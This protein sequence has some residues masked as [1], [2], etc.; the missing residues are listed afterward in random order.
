MTL[1]WRLYVAA[2]SVAAMLALGMAPPANAAEKEPVIRFVYKNPTGWWPDKVAQEVQEAAKKLGVDYQIIGPQ[3]ADV[4]KQVDMIEGFVSDKVDVLIVSSLGP[5][6][7][8]AV[9]DA[10]RDGIKVVM[11]DSDCPKSHRLAFFGANDTSLGADAGALY[12]EATKGK[13][14]Q[15]ILVVTG[16]P[17]AENLMQREQGFKDKLK[18]L[19]VDVQYLPTIPC[20]EDTQ[21]AVDAIESALRGDPTI[22]GVYVTAFW[23]FEA[24]AK[25]FPLMTKGVKDGKLTVVNVDGLPGA[26]KM[27]E[28]G[29]IYGSVAQNLGQFAV[30]PLN[31]AYQVGIKGIKYPSTCTL[32]S[33]ILTKDGGPGRVKAGDFLKKNWQDV[34][35]DLH[36][37]SPDECK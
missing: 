1:S 19:G 15:K 21:K 17:G 23:P 33:Q 28:Q 8:Q 11:A 30:A 34:D 7:C 2:V 18:E 14:P 12:A 3:G 22:T 32:G 20:Y 6:S 25:N 35:W 9:E 31:L 16:T 24:D 37:L 13:G 10:I 5:A 36:T 27:V 4:A 26:L 29:Y